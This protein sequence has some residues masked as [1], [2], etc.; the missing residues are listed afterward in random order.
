MK[1]YS[2]KKNYQCFD[3]IYD[4]LNCSIFVNSLL[5]I[6]KRILAVGI[7]NSN[8]FSYSIIN[9]GIAL[10]DINFRQVVTFI[11][12]EYPTSIYKLNNDLFV[13]AC[14]SANDDNDALVP[15][16]RINFYYIDEL[17]GSKDCLVY[18]SSINSGTKD[19]VHSLGESDSFGKLIISGSQSVRAFQ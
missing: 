7:K 11:Q 10:I 9:D 5:M 12:S 17:N 19:F 16:K 18:I 15:Q 14:N 6:N 13:I 4:D 1:F 3:T 8:A 2:S